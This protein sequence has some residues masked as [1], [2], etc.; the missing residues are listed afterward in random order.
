MSSAQDGPI[1]VNGTVTNFDAETNSVTIRHDAIEEL[2][3]PAM[4][5]TFA[6]R[7]NLKNHAFQYDRP[8]EFAISKGSDK[9]FSLVDLRDVKDQASKTAPADTVGA[10]EK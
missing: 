7:A 9:R 10:D 5:T 1:W 8:I 6:V 2:Q 4:E 3:W